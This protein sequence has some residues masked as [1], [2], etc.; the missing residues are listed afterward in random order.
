MKGQGLLWEAP[1]WVDVADPEVFVARFLAGE[2]TDDR[3][4][5]LFAALRRGERTVSELPARTEIPQATL[6]Q[7]LGI[8]RTKGVVI[9]RRDG[10]HVHYSISNPK[11]FQAFDLISEVMAEQLEVRKSTVDV[12]LGDS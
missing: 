9:A 3:L 10:A 5:R 7:H 1:A 2:P 12:A 8:L 6:S 11:I 4:W